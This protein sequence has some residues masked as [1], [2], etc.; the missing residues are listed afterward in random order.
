MG[1]YGTHRTAA[2]IQTPRAVPRSVAAAMDSRYN[3]PVTVI[4]QG[5]IAMRI[6]G[7]VFTIMLAVCCAHVAAPA[8]D[9]Q[10]TLPADEFFAAKAE[11]GGALDQAMTISAVHLAQL[12]LHT[13]QVG[14]ELWAVQYGNGHYPQHVNQMVSEP[15]K[16]IELGIYANPFTSNAWDHFDAVEVPFGW[17]EMHPGNFSYLQIYDESG[18]VIGY[19][20]LGYGP[21]RESGQD[22]DGDGEPDGVILSLASSSEPFPNGL[23]TFISDGRPVTIDMGE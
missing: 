9:E 5:R 16:S 6:L 20:L 12:G 1:R 19:V 4:T 23:T 22:V 10:P 14:L 17:S 18:N 8:Q 21:T 15:S 3:Y 13:V 2:K 11:A 7:F